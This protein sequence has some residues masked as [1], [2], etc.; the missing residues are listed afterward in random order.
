ME[1]SWLGILLPQFLRSQKDLGP[2]VWGEGS[3]RSGRVQDKFW[4]KGDPSLLWDGSRGRLDR[5]GFCSEMLWLS[6]AG[7][8]AGTIS[9]PSMWNT[10]LL[11][12][13]HPILRD[14][15]WPF[16]TRTSCSSWRPLLMG[17]TSDSH[18]QGL[19]GR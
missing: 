15:G 19:R 16:V 7:V 18:C 8:P 6:L 2:R 14:S 13:P 5:N 12:G 11:G 3:L 9:W 1:G 10:G 4:G 17:R